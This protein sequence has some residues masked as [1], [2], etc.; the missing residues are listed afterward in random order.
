VPQVLSAEIVPYYAQILFFDPAGAESIP[1][2]ETS[3]EPVASS[4][5]GLAVFTRSDWVQSANDVVP[6]TIEVWLNE[7]PIDFDGP[8]VWRGPI[9][10]GEQGVNV[11][12]VVGGDLHSVAISPGSYTVSVL[13]SPVEMPEHVVFVVD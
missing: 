1:M 4:D 13:A 8:E 7:A 10:I 2:S 6:V 11:G 3:M 9:V 5:S 12:S